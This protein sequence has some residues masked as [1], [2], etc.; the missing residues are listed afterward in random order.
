MNLI[1]QGAEIEN[2]DLRTLAKFS[3]A[4]QIERITGEAF[5]LLDAKPHPEIEPLCKETSLDF[6]FVPPEKKLTDFGLVAMDMDSTLLSIESIDEIADFHGV[7][8]E[9]SAITQSTMRGEINF[10][11][12]LT[13]RAALLEGLPESALQHVYDE[14]LRLSPGA[15]KMLHRMK[16][17]GIRT[18]VIS[19]GFTFFTD[20]VKTRLGLDYA[21]A[22][23]LDIQNGKLT[24]LVLGHIIGA[25]G[26]GEILEQVRNQLGLAKEQV[27]AIGDGANDL[28][29][30]DTAGVGIAFHAKPILQAHATYC[31]NHVGLDGVL[32]FFE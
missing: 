31:I 27:I 18:M 4:N 1:I 21:F 7:K 29:M 8:A 16:S 23:T 9:V 10:A 24:G 19:G 17:V 6:A 20:R 15:K 11:E 12:S 5:R 28:K 14:R 13:R 2:S 3:G 26:K 32:N 22:N 25:T 30:L